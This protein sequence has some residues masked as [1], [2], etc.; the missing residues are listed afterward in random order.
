MIQDKESRLKSIL[1]QI[2]ETEGLKDEDA[3]AIDPKIL[4]S[5]DMT[6]PKEYE[7]ELMASEMLAHLQNYKQA[8][9]AYQAAR[10]LGQH[11]RAEQLSKQVT[12]SRL[13]VALIQSQ[14]PEAKAIADQLA[15]ANVKR[16][17]TT[18]KAMLKGE[19]TK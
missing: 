9:A 16:A 15:L 1:E 8:K 11:D 17:E 6:L 12:F 19:D 10:N 2:T 3:P 7:A 14:Y 18:R 13:A 4:E 5:V